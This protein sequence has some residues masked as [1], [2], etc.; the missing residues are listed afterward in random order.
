MGNNLKLFHYPFIFIVLIIA[1]QI[2][3]YFFYLYYRSR[4]EKLKINSSLLAFGLLYGFGFTG[5][6]IRTINSYY[7]ED[8]IM[9][10]FLLKFSHISIFIAVFSFLLIISQ[11]SFN[12]LVNTKITK[13]VSVITIALSILIF[14]INDN[15]I[16]GILLLVSLFI[17]GVYMLFFHI[18]LIKKSTGDIRK[19]LLFLLIGEI[20]IVLVIVIGAEKTPYIFSPEQ[21]NIIAILYNPLV[22]LGQL[23]VFYSIYD[24]PIFLEFEWQNNI[25]N[26]YIID[27]KRLKIIFQYNFVKNNKEQLMIKQDSESLNIIFSGGIIGIEKIISA[28]TKSRESKIEKIRQGDYFVLLNQGKDDL[29]FLTYCILVKKDMVSIQY[30]LKLIKKEFTKLYGKILLDLKSIEEK[31]SQIFVEFNKKIENILKTN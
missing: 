22:I 11:K 19:R 28:I 6:V 10:N 30:F 18:K 2:S 29:A 9:F 25:L 13:V 8:S 20:L 27:I 14:F 15:T 17:G 12:E 21:Q 23:I 24:F 1:Y 31:E 5:V 26:L 3:A 7:V 16:L 4:K